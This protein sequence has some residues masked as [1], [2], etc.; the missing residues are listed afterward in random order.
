MKTRIL[1]GVEL[2]LVLIPIFVLGDLALEIL[3]GLFV[4]GSTYELYRMHSSK[5]QMNIVLLIVQSIISLAIYYYA[6]EYFKGDLILEYVFLVILF[7]LI[8]AS[9]RKSVV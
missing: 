9:D 6:L 3:L 5:A 8:V 7:D 2:G 1:T 4:I